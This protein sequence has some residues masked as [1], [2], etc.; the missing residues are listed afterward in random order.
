MDAKGVQSLVTL[1]AVI[2]SI[3]IS[4]ET[5]AAPCG[6]KNSGNF[7]DARFLFSGNNLKKEGFVDGHTD[8]Y[9]Q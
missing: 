7:K 2:L 5:D 9:A 6:C 8:K 1:I 3:N 4:L